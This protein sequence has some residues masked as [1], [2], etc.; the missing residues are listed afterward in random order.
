MI[1]SY[2]ETF[3]KVDVGAEIKVIQHAV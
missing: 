2:H 1:G 3:E